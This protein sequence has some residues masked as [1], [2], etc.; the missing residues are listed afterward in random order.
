MLYNLD[1]F[2]V[3]R[4][5]NLIIHCLLKLH[6]SIDDV[7]FDIFLIAIIGIRFAMRNLANNHRKYMAGALVMLIAQ[8][9]T[10]FT[11]GSN[12]H[13]KVNTFMCREASNVIFQI[14]DPIKISKWCT[15]SGHANYTHLDLFLIS[16]HP[17]LS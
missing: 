10:N 9:V 1:N 3:C 11:N 15:W 16:Y 13:R 6:L 5:W 4:N 7:D 2:L 17:M 14:K 8:S 12:T